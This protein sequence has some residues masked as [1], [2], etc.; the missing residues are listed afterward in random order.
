MGFDGGS[1][2][3]GATSHMAYHGT[4]STI[5]NGCMEYANP[6]CQF[7]VGRDVARMLSK[8]AGSKNMQTPLEHSFF[9]TA[10]LPRSSRFE[11]WRE[12]IGVMFEVRQDESSKGAEFNALVD[13][14][15]LD[16][17]V[18]SR[19]CAHGQK[20]E[21]NR[22]RLARD[23]ME[24]YMIQL[25]TR[26]RVEM[27]LGRSHIIAPTRTIVGFDL[28][29]TLDSVNTDFDLLSAFIPREKLAPL[30]RFP[31]NVQGTVVDSS[32]GEGKIFADFMEAVFYNAPSLSREMAQMTAASLIHMAAAA[33]NQSRDVLDAVPNASMHST[34]LRAKRY[35]DSN[36][37][38]EEL[39][40]QQVAQAIGASRSSLF[41]A[42]EPCSGVGNYIRHRRLNRALRRLV[43]GRSDGVS[44]RVT[45]VALEF[46]YSSLAQ[47]S[48]H[49]KQ[50][51]GL[52]PRDAQKSGQQFFGGNRQFEQGEGVSD[53]LYEKWLATVL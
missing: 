24:H 36:L 42:F 40:P 41:R 9:S 50:E 12:S 49:F 34:L 7:L 2:K 26:G 8:T 47:F 25:F 29:D 35:I 44:L 4:S 16:C 11:A 32:Q 17:M 20:F 22:L 13:S 19:C 39:S 10:H 33:L 15:L 37:D 28:G 27:N 48:R 46:G 51:F 43:S 5:R 30:L 6:I 45:D 52:S 1:Q 14:Y 38:R 3:L 31:D 53:R 23:G 18:L 21:R